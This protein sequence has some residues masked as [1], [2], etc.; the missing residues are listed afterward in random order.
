[1]KPNIFHFATSELSQDAILCWLLS[2]AKPEN[3]IEDQDLHQIGV[4]LLILI[5]KLA[6]VVVPH[7]IS[8]VEVRKQPANI[9]VL[10]IINRKTAIIIEDKSGSKQHSDQLP[11]Y[12]DHV[13]KE[14]G[15]SA[16][17]V[18]PVYIQ[19]GDESDYS[20][21]VKHGYFVLKR[22]DLLGILESDKGVAARKKSDILDNF[23]AHL[24]QI[25]DDVHSYMNLPLKE[26][27]WNSWKGFYSHLQ[28]ALGEGTWDYVPNHSGG[29]LGFWWYHTGN[30]DCEIYLQLEQEKFCF[31]IV[32]DGTEKSC[33][34]RK[35]WHDLV[36]SKCP[37]RGLRARKPARFGSGEYVTFAILDQE[38]RVVDKHGL[39]DF[40]ATIRILE[41][42]QSVLDD[43][44]LPPA[45]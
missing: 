43:C 30:D 16:N 12:K 31:K 38:Y 37:G 8:S 1:M 23:W 20:E 26:W 36:V 17:D 29:F 21:V 42:A 34:L 22:G 25:D 13:L 45:Q 19:T 32:M 44:L 18:I 24:R 15:F 28:N 39:L 14:L 27:I 4:D 7:K 41:A 5:H 40:E 11:R 35:H 9:D 10:C 6:K 2:W 33:E 3:Q